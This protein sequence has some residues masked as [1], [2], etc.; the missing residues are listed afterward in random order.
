LILIDLI[1]LDDVLVR[2]LFAGIRV[3]LQIPDTVAGLLVGRITNSP[4]A[5]PDR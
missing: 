4:Y 2:H 1:T 3:D 5:K